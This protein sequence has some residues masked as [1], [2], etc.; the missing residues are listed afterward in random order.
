MYRRAHGMWSDRPTNFG[1]VIEGKLAGSGL[2]VTRAQ[3]DGALAAGIKSIVT[4]REVALPPSWVNNNDGKA[5]VGYMH[6]QVDDFD[7]PPVEDIDRAVEFIDGEIKSGRPV[8][9]H[10]AAGKGRTGVILAAYLVKKERLTSEQAIE[11]VRSIRP[12]SVQSEV[13]EWAVETYEKYLKGKN[14]NK[15]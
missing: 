12:G 10:C 15:E 1:W 14:N 4:V 11:K 9:V 13:Q 5:D 2:P 3:F 8:M 6:L 7:A